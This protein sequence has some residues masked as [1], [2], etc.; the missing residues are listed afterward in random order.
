MDVIGGVCAAPPRCCTLNNVKHANEGLHCVKNWPALVLPL[1]RFR[2]S[3]TNTG[4]P[5]RVSPVENDLEN[6]LHFEEMH[7]HLGKVWH[8]TLVEVARVV[9]GCSPSQID[10]VLLHNVMSQLEQERRRRRAP[11]RMTVAS[12]NN[13]STAREFAPAQGAQ[14]AQPLQPHEVCT[15]AT[16]QVK[17]FQALEVGPLH[18]MTLSSD[19]VQMGIVGR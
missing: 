3:K 16:F 18:R 11:H 13:S 15:F 2:A 6:V 12:C 14:G 17:K 5:S 1:L 7:A 8:I 19:W 10:P 9:R 4:T